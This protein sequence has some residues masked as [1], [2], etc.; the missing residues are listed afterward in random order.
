MTCTVCSICMIIIYIYYTLINA[1]SALIIHI[2]PNTMSYTP[3]EDSSTKTI[4][5]RNYM[6]T[7]THTHTNE[8]AHACLSDIGKSEL[9]EIIN[10]R[11]L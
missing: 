4:Y 11:R 7:H 5:V 6:E 8:R 1:L 2:N 3:V 10:N 9:Q